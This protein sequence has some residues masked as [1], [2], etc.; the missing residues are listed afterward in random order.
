MDVLV[1]RPEKFRNES[2]SV[3]ICCVNL[4]K[5]QSISDFPYRITHRAGIA[6]RSLLSILWSEE[7]ITFSTPVE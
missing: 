6:E 2:D 4:F 3:S 7:G 1:E 5:K